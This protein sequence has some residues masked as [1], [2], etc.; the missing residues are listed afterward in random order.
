MTSNKSLNPNTL[1]SFDSYVDTL[2]T[3]DCGLGSNPLGA[4]E[5]VADFWASYDGTKMDK[6]YDFSQ[7]VDLSV[8]VGEYTGMPPERIFFSNG[9]ISM[10]SNI[11]FKLFSERPKLMVGVGPQFVQAV[12]EWQ[13][14]GGT[15]SDD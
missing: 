10:L 2:Y 9:S 8:K 11:F 4:P 1:K 7:I 12:S 5:S 6:Y 14:S 13:L 3:I 15:Q